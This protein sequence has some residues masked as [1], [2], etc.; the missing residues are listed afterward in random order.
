[1]GK[2]Q[3]VGLG[4][5][6]AHIVQLYQSRGREIFPAPLSRLWDRLGRTFTQGISAPKYSDAGLQSV[7]RSI[8]V[9]SATKPVSNP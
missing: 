8:P 3:T 6:A 7:L 5:T 2:E 1:V 4:I 9:R